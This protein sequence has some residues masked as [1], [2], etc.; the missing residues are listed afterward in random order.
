[1][2]NAYFCV[3][4]L[5]LPGRAGDWDADSTAESA[6]PAIPQVKLDARGFHGGRRKM[7]GAS[8]HDRFEGLVEQGSILHALK[9]FC[10]RRGV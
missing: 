1:V 4:V 10:S 7:A 2:P 5:S 6:G 8:K 3:A 9:A